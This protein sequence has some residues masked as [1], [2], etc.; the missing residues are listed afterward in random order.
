MLAQVFYRSGRFSLSV[1]K[2]NP[3]IITLTV[4]K[5]IAYLLFYYLLWGVILTFIDHT[6]FSNALIAY[7]TV[8]ISLISSFCSAIDILPQ[9]QDKAKETKHA[10]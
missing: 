6:S 2:K 9:K 1:G 10:E 7:R 8:F 4:R 5:A 3:V